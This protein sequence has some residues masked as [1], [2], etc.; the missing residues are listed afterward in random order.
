MKKMIIAS[1]STLH[2]GQYLEYIKDQIASL[3]EGRKSIL[4]VPFARPGGISWDDYT[5]RAATFFRTLGI[6]VRGLHEFEDKVEAISQAEGIF[7]GG[8]NTFVLVNELYRHN[9]MPVLKEAVNSGTPYLGSS[10]GS[11]IT[12]L[13]MQTTNDMPIVQVPDYRTIGA[14]PFNLNP[15]YLDPD[16]EGKHMGETRETRIKEFHIYNSVPVLGLREGSWLNVS[17]DKI[18]LEGGLEARLFRQGKE[19][20]ELESGSDLSGLR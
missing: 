12:G 13:S 19:A 20:T 11:N 16:P 6:D 9:L 2:G 5:S 4:F 18:T 10:A 8:G 17:G 7:T 1:T 14:I 15:H 3:F